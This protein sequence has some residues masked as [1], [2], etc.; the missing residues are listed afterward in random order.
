MYMKNKTTAWKLLNRGLKRYKH[1]FENFWYLGLQR[2]KKSEKR[3]FFNFTN[4]WHFLGHLKSVKFS[5]INNWSY[6]ICNSNHKNPN[7]EYENL[8]LWIWWPFSWKF[9]F[10]AKGNFSHFVKEN[11]VLRPYTG[12]ILTQCLSK[13]L[14]SANRRFQHTL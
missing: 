5:N 2:L 12:K 13:Y 11:N 14:F 4:F 7:L 3:L 9:D 6:S 8:F 10:P 1:Q